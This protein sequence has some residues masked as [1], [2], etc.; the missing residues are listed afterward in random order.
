MRL[1]FCVACASTT[2]LHQHHLVPRVLGGPDTQENILT[3]CAPCHTKMHSLQ[4]SGL[5]NSNTLIQVGKWLA[6]YDNDRDPNG[7]TNITAEGQARAAQAFAETVRPAVEDFFRECGRSNR[8]TFAKLARYLT[9]RNIQTRL[10]GNEWSVG[11]VYELVGRLKLDWMAVKK[12]AIESSMVEARAKNAAAQETAI[13]V[14]N[15]ALAALKPVI[16]EYKAVIGNDPP[17]R[18][19]AA[20]LNELGLKTNGDAAWTVNRLRTAYVRSAKPQTAA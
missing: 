2:D 17:L 15:A 8:P 3:L 9:N 6:E 19:Q 4:S 18:W 7:G 12:H 1:D 16:S 20:K 5:L 11:Q 14:D 13:A 10:G